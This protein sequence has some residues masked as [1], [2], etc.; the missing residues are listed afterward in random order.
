M[1]YENKLKVQYIYHSCFLVETENTILIFDYFKGR[2]PD[3]D[4]RKKIYV[5]AS[6]KHND[7]LSFDIFRWSEKYRN[8]TYILSKDIKMNEN[9]MN[10]KEIPVQIRSQIYYIGKEETSLFDKVKVETLTS[11]DE[12]VAFLVTVDG[13]S[14]YHAGDLNWW[15]WIGETE[16]EA[17]DRER[18]FI[19]EMEK[20]QGRS[21]DIA[22]V[23]LDPRQEERFFWGFDYFM[24]VTETK[25]AFP[26]HC[27]GDYS[28]IAILKE[29]GCAKGYK[30][31]IIEIDRENMS[32][33]L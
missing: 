23:P 24:R 29:M 21:F 26:M 7:H 8:I 9:Y 11:T 2:L 14:I 4:D 20:I 32:F 22:F 5:F 12:G 10:R 19:R 3:L 17:I 18:R 16:E 28:I 33:A 30:E 27:W 25:I 15:S 1:N 6:H 13:K 31:K